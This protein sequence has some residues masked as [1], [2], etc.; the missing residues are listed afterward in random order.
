MSENNQSISII[1]RTRRKIEEL[2]TLQGC[3]EMKWRC[4]KWA[5]ND[6]TE[7]MDHHSIFLGSYLIWQPQ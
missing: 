3:M 5:M 2:L 7:D 6:E 4:R 1:S